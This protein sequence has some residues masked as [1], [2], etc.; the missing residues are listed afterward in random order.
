MQIVN[1]AN[2]EVIDGHNVI[3]RSGYSLR[4]FVAHFMRR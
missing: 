3:L 4:P 2:G 1:V